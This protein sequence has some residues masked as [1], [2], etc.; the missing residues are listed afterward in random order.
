MSA[1]CAYTDLLATECAHCRG[2]VGPEVAPEPRRFD[3]ASP[4]RKVWPEPS[5]PPVHKPPVELAPTEDPVVKVSRGLR[6]IRMMAPMLNDRGEDLATSSEGPGGDATATAAP[7]ASPA[8]WERR[9]ELAEEAWDTLALTENLPP[10]TRPSTEDE[11]WEAP[12]QT[13]L[14]WSEEYRTRLDMDSGLTPTLNTEANFLAN[15]DV[16]TW[17]RDNEP[18]WDDFAQDVADT[19]TRLE[20]IVRAGIRTTRSRILCDKHHLG[21]HE[22]KAHKKLTVVYGDGDEAAGY[23]APCC[24]ARYTPDEAKRAH[25]RQMRSAGAERWV[26]V[27]E[28][29]DALRVQGWQERTVMR[30]VEPLRPRDECTECGEWWAH[31]QYAACPRKVHS[32][33]VVTD[34]G[35]ELATVMVGDREAVPSAYCEVASR[36]TMAWW[37]D[38]WRR[39]LMARH[40]REQGKSA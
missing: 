39:H 23:I 37:P 21:S 36:R 40:E 9:Y 35:G 32:A 12:L 5:Q 31:Q 17:I 20:N 25:S 34:C 18:R 24:H 1:R 27:R 2:D 4:G 26:R 28:A 14:F 7:V 10:E 15:H 29:V 16:L 38:L 11:I 30:W 6:S 3:D 13:L 22:G 19:V 33:G 8:T